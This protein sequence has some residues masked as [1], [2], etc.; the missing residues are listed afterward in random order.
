MY[1]NIYYTTVKEKLED[2]SY[3]DSK[4][5]YILNGNFKEQFLDSENF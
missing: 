3:C 2:Q 1:T 4:K 5:V